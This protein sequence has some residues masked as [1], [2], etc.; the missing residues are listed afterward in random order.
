MAHHVSDVFLEADGT[1]SIDKSPTGSS[2]D[3]ALLAR[4][5]TAFAMSELDNYSSACAE[6][7]SFQQVTLI[8]SC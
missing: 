3:S 8:V 6:P 5:G 7:K 1:I 4:P 2:S